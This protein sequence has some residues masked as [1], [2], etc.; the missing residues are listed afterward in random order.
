METYTPD[1][2]AEPEILNRL[3]ESQLRKSRKSMKEIE[4]E[5]EDE[6]IDHLVDDLVPWHTEEEFVIAVSGKAFAILQR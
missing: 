3:S 6:D 5:I 2:T 4:K 1:Y